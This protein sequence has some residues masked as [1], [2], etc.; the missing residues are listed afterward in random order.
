MA[1]ATSDFSG[2]TCLVAVTGVCL[3]DSSMSSN[4]LL[5]FCKRELSTSHGS[6]CTQNEV[7]IPHAGT[8]YPPLMLQKLNVNNP[9]KCLLL[10]FCPILTK[11]GICRQ[12]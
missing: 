9:V 12:I 8:P 2:I 4:G 11:T 6:Q 1:P 10:C 3:G 7:K 5:G